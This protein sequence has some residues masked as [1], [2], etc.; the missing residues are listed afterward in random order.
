MDTTLLRQ[1]LGAFALHLAASLALVGVFFLLVFYGWYPDPLFKLE[2]TWWVVGLLLGIDVVLG[3]LLTG[4]VYRPGKKSLLFDLSVIVLLQAGAFL[5]G[6]SLIVSER[7]LYIAFAIDRFVVIPA[8][9]VDED[10]P[11]RHPEL[12]N[13]LGL[14]PKWVYVE[15]PS[16][17]TERTKLLAQVMGGG[18]DMEY[19]PRYYRPY[20]APYVPMMQRRSL[21]PKRVVKVI[22]SA[23]PL[24]DEALKRAG[25][26]AQQVMLFP[27]KGK[28]HNMLVMVR[29]GDARL[30]EILDINLWG[31]PK[32]KSP[33][34]S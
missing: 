22:P 30:L 21:T 11:M 31:V 9:M 16:D 27:L 23:K 25:V 13:R 19:L 7:P 1:K 3:P 2:G 29:R 10:A 4:V 18:K 14:G 5:Y 20:G 34:Q 24:L 33:D 15:P 32:P 17:R 12:K 6:A 26:T 8:A 28:Q